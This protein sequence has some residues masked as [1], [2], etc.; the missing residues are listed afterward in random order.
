[1]AAA[2]LAAAHPKARIALL[3]KDPVLGGRLRTTSTDGERVFSYGLNAVSERL[4]DFWQQTLR[5][6]AET[7]DAAV[8]S[9]VASQT[10]VGILAGNKISDVDIDLWFSSKGARALGGY[11][12]A[13]QWEE[14]DHIVHK[15]RAGASA[16][17]G[18]DAEEESEEE[19]AEAEGKLKPFGHYWSKPRKAP[20][21]VVL[22]FFGGAFGIPDVWSAH[23]TAIAER[24]GFHGT[25]LRCGALA[26]VLKQTTEQPTFRDCVQVFTHTRI[27]NAKY[28]N[29]QWSIDA[30][31]GAFTAPVLVVAQPPWQATEWLPR[32]YWP[33]HVISIASKTKPVSVVVLS[34]RIVKGTP[35]SLPDVV[36]VPAERVQVLHNG[37]DEIAF[38]ATIDFELSLQAPAVLKAVRQLKRAKKKLLAL[39]PDLVLAGDHIA[40]QP[41]AWAQSPSSSDVRWI[42]KLGKKSFNA[43]HLVFCGDAY[44]GSYDGDLNL[45]K[46]VVSAVESADYDVK[47]VP[48]QP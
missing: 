3:E 48:S 21:A 16:A 6:D 39:Y 30:E 17:K 19:D 36:L 45:I 47:S 20:A 44:G 15:Q 40:L 26:N 27:G 33:P 34:E 7:D 41:V 9:G 38:Q 2:R 4:F 5:Q 43:K 31:G 37:K 22:E 35:E 18:D 13:R 11:T 25:K 14:V 23:P 12:A 8:M 42:E 10:K 32:Q 24:A 1:M 29:E 28:E 46:S